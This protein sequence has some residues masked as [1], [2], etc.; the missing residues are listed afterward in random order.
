MS[1]QPPGGSAFSRR[2]EPFLVGIEA[3]W[4]DPAQD[5]ANLG[6][7]RE[8]YADLERFSRGGVYLNFPGFADERDS[9][10]MLRDAY[11]GSFDRL[12]TVKAKYDPDNVFRSNFNISQELSASA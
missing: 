6:W 3:N 4:D 2:N 7:A 10:Q 9:D 5:A 12:R 1:K 8:L 11:A